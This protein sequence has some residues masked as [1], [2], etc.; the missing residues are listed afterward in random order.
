M[1]ISDDKVLKA[2]SIT[3]YKPTFSALQ[4][5]MTLQQPVR[6]SMKFPKR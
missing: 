3:E 5:L 6:P 1:R 4:S 2:R